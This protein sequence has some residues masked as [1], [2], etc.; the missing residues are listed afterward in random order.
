MVSYNDAIKENT[1]EYKSVKKPENRE[2][3]FLD[4]NY[5]DFETL[6]KKYVPL[7]FKRR[8]KSVLLRITIIK[9]I[10]RRIKR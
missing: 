9:K 1:A 2:S 10:C 7:S 5:N 6:S 3:F 4:M 8:V